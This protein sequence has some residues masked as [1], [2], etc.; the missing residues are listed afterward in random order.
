VNDAAQHTPVINPPS[1]RLVPWKAGLYRRPLLV[2]QPEFVRH[3]ILLSSQE[4]HIQTPN[5]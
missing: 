5:Q 1:A 3:V 2:A 4:N